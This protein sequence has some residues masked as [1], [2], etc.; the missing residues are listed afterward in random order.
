MRARYTMRIGSRRKVWAIV[1]PGEIGADR[2]SPI[3]SSSG[4]GCSAA[5]TAAALFA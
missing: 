3:G 2:P 4:A 1:L 5:S